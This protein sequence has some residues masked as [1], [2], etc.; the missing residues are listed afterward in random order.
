MYDTRPDLRSYLMAARRLWFIVAATAALGAVTAALTTSGERV[1]ISSVVQVTDLSSL[2]NLS[3]SGPLIDAV[4]EAVYLSEDLATQLGDIETNAKAEITH[5]AS[6]PTIDITV[7]GP[8]EASAEELQAEID[9]V[10]AARWT[11]HVTD[12]LEPALAFVESRIE[13][14]QSRLEEIAQSDEDDTPMEVERIRLQEQLIGDQA[15]KDSLGAF[16]AAPPSAAVTVRSSSDGTSKILLA[17]GAMAGVFVGIGATMVLTLMDH[18]VRRRSFVERNGL[19]VVAVADKHGTGLDLIGPTILAAAG[20]EAMP[21]VV[22]PVDARTDGA[23]PF[24]ILDSDPHFDAVEL[25]ESVPPEPGFVSGV[26]AAGAVVLVAVAG[27]T[28][29]ADL[30]EAAR[31]ASAA[32]SQNVCAVL[33]APSRGAYH[34]LLD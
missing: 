12:A 33:V 26:T 4:A 2:S 14:A 15:I 30:F 20:E 17:A 11:D 34:E 16:I 5:R 19:P 31:A 22:A 32:G 29:Y 10:L 23:G 28:T 6:R 8:D 7:T 9:Q 21:I 13:S 3:G 1:E 24:E 18:R 27:R 25:L